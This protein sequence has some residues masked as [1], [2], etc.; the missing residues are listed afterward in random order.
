MRRLHPAVELLAT[1]GE[2]AGETLV[3]HPLLLEVVRHEERAAGIALAREALVPGL[4][5][6][7]GEGTLEGLHGLHLLA[8]A[9]LVAVERM[10][11][12]LAQDEEIASPHARPRGRRCD[13]RRAA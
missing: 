7:A 4:A 10:A 12:R 9:T 1:G 13:R 3:P 8:D 6:D 11:R 5:V 2:I